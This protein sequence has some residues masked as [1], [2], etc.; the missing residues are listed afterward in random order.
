MGKEKVCKCGLCGEE[1]LCSF[2]GKNNGNLLYVCDE[3]INE[4]LET[5]YQRMLEKNK[6][7]YA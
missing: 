2:I 6:V 5:V 3:C 4:E 7:Q 1:N